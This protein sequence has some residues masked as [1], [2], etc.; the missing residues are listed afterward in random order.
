MKVVGRWVNQVVALTIDK[1]HE[2]TVAEAR[3]RNLLARTVQRMQQR[4]SVL[5]LDLWHAHVLGAMQE[6]ADEAR[7]SVFVQRVIG[8]M[9]HAA[10]ASGFGRWCDNAR[11]LHRQRGVMGRVVLRMKTTGMCA[12]LQRWREALREQKAVYSKGQRVVLRWK[13]QAV[14]WCLEAWRELTAEEARKRNL[15]RRIV[16]RMLRR[17]L[18]LAMDLWM[19]RIDDA[20]REAEDDERKK[21]LMGKIWTRILGRVQSKAFLQWRDTLCDL[22]RLHQVTGRLFS[23]VLLRKLWGAFARWYHCS[24]GHKMKGA[25]T[26]KA[27]GHWVQ[28][29]S[30]RTLLVW[31][32]HAA[33]EKKKQN[34]FARVFKRLQ[35]L[36]TFKA[37]DSWAAKVSDAARQRARE[38]LL[39]QEEREHFNA[40]RDILEDELLGLQLQHE[41]LQEEFQFKFEEQ[42]R[43]WAAAQ[44][45]VRRLQRELDALEAVYKVRAE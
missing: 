19:H 21:K 35:N 9:M 29:T 30:A 38:E 18:S 6:R 12:A 23:K 16:A 36:R 7:R 45:L 3:R 17:S 41:A 32:Q 1:W 13:L 42:Q 5:A 14:V 10:L 26:I 8:R 11:E 24:E 2:H 31:H 37:F 4:C 22:A 43:A 34:V 25:Q 27:M 20:R 39:L 44:L 15:M 28:N 40:A 33:H